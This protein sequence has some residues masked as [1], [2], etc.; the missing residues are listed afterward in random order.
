MIAPPS[1]VPVVEIDPPATR[2]TTPTLLRSKVAISTSCVAGKVL[3]ADAPAGAGSPTP[4]AIDTVVPA[5]IPAEVPV[6]DLLPEICRKRVVPTFFV[7]TSVAELVPAILKKLL[8]RTPTLTPTVARTKA[9]PEDC[10]LA[11]ADGRTN[12]LRAML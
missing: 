7:I 9:I 10:N 1:I 12:E 3:Q 4:V 5:A 6:A 11:V 8:R 2:F